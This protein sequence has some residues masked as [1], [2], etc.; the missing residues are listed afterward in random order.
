[1]QGACSAPSPLPLQLGSPC[2]HSHGVNQCYEGRHPYR[3][4]ATV[5]VVVVSLP[6]A[7]EEAAADPAAGFAVPTCTWQ[8]RSAKMSCAQRNTAQRHSSNAAPLAR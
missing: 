2:G 8:G 6:A 1:M 7:P 5:V 4:A 3:P